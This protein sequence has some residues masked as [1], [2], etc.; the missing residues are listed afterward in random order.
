MKR[1]RE[2]RIGYLVDNRAEVDDESED[3]R[4]K[5]EVVYVFG[6]DSRVTKEIVC[7][8]FDREY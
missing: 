1:R 7:D 3:Y 8:F 6:L 5:P 2:K 4:E